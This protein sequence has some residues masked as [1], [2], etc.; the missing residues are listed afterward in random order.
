MSQR[1]A[2]LPMGALA[3]VL[4]ATLS[5]GAALA[6]GG[7]GGGMG[8]GGGSAGGGSSGGG[9]RSS[10]GASLMRD[11]LT[12]CPRGQVWS[13]KRRQCL[14][15]HSGVLPDPELTEY[16]FALAKAKRFDEALAT[17][18]MLDNPNTPR[19]LN[20]RG[21]ATRKLGRTDEGIGYYMKSVAM[22]PHYAQVREYLGEAY[23]I[24]GKMAEAKQQLQTIQTICGTD[25]EEYEDLDDAIKD[26]VVKDDS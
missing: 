24:Q 3:L 5:I 14:A 10:G 23:V 13:T 18:D 6:A 16:A 11:D 9:S 1:L 4:S 8:G 19:A 25:C 21:Y 17:L 2:I 12:T 20:Y 15:A 22:D 7:G 26:G